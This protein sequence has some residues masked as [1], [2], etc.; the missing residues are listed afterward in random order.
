MKKKIICCGYGDDA[1]ILNNWIY[2][3]EELHGEGS[4]YNLIDKLLQGQCNKDCLDDQEV[5]IEETEDAYK[6]YFK[7]DEK[8]ENEC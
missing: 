8:E 7:D 1:A 3:Y 6:L 5:C 2:F 4:R